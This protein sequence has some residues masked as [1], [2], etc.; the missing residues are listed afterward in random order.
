MEEPNTLSMEALPVRIEPNSRSHYMWLSARIARAEAR[1]QWRRFKRVYGRV[2]GKVDY[3]FVAYATV[4]ALRTAGCGTA[5]WLFE[6]VMI[7]TGQNLLDAMA[8]LGMR[9]E[10]GDGSTPVV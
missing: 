8:L 6:G 10:R 7:A 9:I 1:R 3:R 4:R 2:P 5:V